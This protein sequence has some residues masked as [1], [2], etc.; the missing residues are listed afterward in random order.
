MLVGD[1]IYSNVERWSK[2]PC[3]ILDLP[4]TSIRIDKE[5]NT[6]AIETT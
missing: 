4:V 6:L 5:R 3:R 1:L 2:P